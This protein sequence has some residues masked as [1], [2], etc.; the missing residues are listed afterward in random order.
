M[1]GLAAAALV[2]AAG[3]ARGAE[4]VEVAVRAVQVDP[5]RGAPVVLLVENAGTHRELSI[6]IGPFE[7]EAIAIELSGVVPPRPLS[8]DLMQELVGRLGGRFERAVIED[9]RANTYFARL[10]LASAT[11]EPVRIDARPSDAIALALR[12]HGRI[13]VE[14]GVFA[15]A[16]S[17]RGTPAALRVWG[18]TLQDVTAD[19]AGFFDLTEPRGVLVSDVADGAPSHDMRRG[20]V[21][22]ALDGT[23]VASAAELVR[24]AEGRT[25]ADPVQM[26][27]RRGRRELSVSF[28][29]R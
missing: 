25:T 14:E 4:P 28:A 29:A 22:M 27:V 17:A 6:W 18:L 3:L 12:L 15:K 19:I 8:H 11:G 24:R 2:L 1:R 10:E 16:A 21:I 5:E 26:S 20:D 7:A 9:L 13:V 23:P